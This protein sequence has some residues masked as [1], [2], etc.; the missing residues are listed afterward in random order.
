MPVY[1]ATFSRV[2]TSLVTVTIGEFDDDDAA[3]E[4]SQRIVRELKDTEAPCV[5]G[6][7]NQL[8]WEED[9]TTY[10]VDELSVET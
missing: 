10:E 8:Q 9:D 2:V 4:D 5:E 1:Q 7:N 3:D 6:L